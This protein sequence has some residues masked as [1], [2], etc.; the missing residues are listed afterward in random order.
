MSLPTT[1]L[2]IET[3]LRRTVSQGEFRRTPELLQCYM[4]E[5]EREVRGVAPGSPAVRNLRVRA[6]ALL[7]WTRTMAN[8]ARAH[9]AGELE[10]LPCLTPFGNPQ[11]HE[12][13]TTI[14]A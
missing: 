3:D 7:D 4:D 5:L 1:L 2:A 6:T 12:P 8:V 9:C 11:P 13:Q 14:D 10:R